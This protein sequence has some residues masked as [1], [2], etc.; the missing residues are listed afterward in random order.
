MASKKKPA[1]KKK[2]VLKKK[3]AAKKKPTKVVARPKPASKPAK[4]KVAPATQAKAKGK[5]KAATAPAPK[6]GKGKPAAAPVAKG[7]GGK[8]AAKAEPVIS[9]EEQRKLLESHRQGHHQASPVEAPVSRPKLL[10]FSIDDVREYLKGRRNVRLNLWI[11]EEERK[12]RERGAK[13]EGKSS[14]GKPNAVGAASLASLLGFNPF[15]KADPVPDTRKIPEKLRRYHKLLTDLRAAL[16]SR[17]ALHAEESLR[18]SGKEDT[19]DLSG[20]SQH[21]ADAATDTADRD[22]ALSLISNEQ[23][24]IKEIDDA[25]ERIKLGTYGTCEVTG[26]SIPHARLMAVP[27]TRYTVEGQRELERQRR[28]Q[29]RRG[30][31]PLGADGDEVGFGTGGGGAEG[32]PEET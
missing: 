22:F 27:F 30:A 3:P 12:S 18:K 11:P 28:A 5:G 20:Y 2:P 19:G 8:A 14:A 10:V 24:T 31:N 7:K 6:G 32:D 9:H 1:P 15:K 26:R 13:G 29:R 16:E 4:V 23:Q 25:I 17:L 21:M